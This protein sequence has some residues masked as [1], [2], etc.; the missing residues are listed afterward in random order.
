MKYL[1]SSFQRA[2]EEDRKRFVTRP[3]EEIPKTEVAEDALSRLV[4]SENV[5]VSFLTMKASSTFELHSHPEEQIMIVTEGYCDEVIENKIYR[6]REGDVIYLPPNIKHGAFI[7]EVDCKVIDVFYP[8]R[9]DFQ[10]KFR[11]QNKTSELRFVDRIQ[12][13]KFREK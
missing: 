1:E 3:F 13:E 2:T 6:V 12:A 11:E 7:R 5:L 4:A 9:E 8:A 10:R